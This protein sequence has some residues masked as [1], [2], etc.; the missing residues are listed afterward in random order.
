M[1]CWLLLPFM[2]GIPLLWPCIIAAENS[3]TEEVRHP[4]GSRLRIRRGWM[5]N[6]FFV[7]E[8]MNKTRHHIGQ[9]RSDLDNGNNSFQYK[10]LG[11]GAE[12]LFVIDERTGDIYAVQKLDREERS[13]YTLRAQVIDTT[14]GRAVEPESEFV[15]RVSD[16]N[17]N[18]PKFL[19]EP[20]EAIV[21]EMSP[22]GIAY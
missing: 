9:L 5:W 7:P 6:Q 10:L 19:D 3:K 21:P 22:E 8:E 16:I 11:V 12:S 13:L 18:E 15:I 14:T 17:D 2:L 1:N 20:Y 4:A